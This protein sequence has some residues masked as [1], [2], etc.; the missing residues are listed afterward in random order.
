MRRGKSILSKDYYLP[1]RQKCGILSCA[2]AG[3]VHRLVHRPSKP[4]RWVRFPL[5][6]PKNTPQLRLWGVFLASSR[7]SNSTAARRQHSLPPPPAAEGASVGTAV[8]NFQANICAPK[9]SVTARGGKKQSGGLFFSARVSA[10]LR[11]RRGLSSTAQAVGCFSIP[12]PP[13]VGQPAFRIPNP[14]PDGTLR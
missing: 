9:I 7:E 2:N 1:N 11:S 14:A 8:Q 3:I 5:P 12:S 6:A 13:A 4:R 10:P